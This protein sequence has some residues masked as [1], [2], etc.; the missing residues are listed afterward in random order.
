MVYDICYAVSFVESYTEHS[1]ECRCCCVYCIFPYVRSSSLLR[2]ASVRICYIHGY[3]CVCF[4][5]C[6]IELSRVSLAIVSCMS[7][8]LF[9]WR[10]S[11]A[12]LYFEGMITASTICCEHLI[13]FIVFVRIC[14]CVRNKYITY[15]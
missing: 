4:W 9:F 12:S 3:V 2:L 8:L 15:V 7:L 5:R 13:C 10:P 6:G 1:M 14:A 11:V